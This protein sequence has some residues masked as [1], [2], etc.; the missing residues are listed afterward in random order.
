MEVVSSYTVNYQDPGSSY[1]ILLFFR[2]CMSVQTEMLI[3]RDSQRHRG[4][5]TTIKHSH[6]ALQVKILHKQW[7]PKLSL[8][9]KHLVACFRKC[10]FRF[11]GPK[12]TYGSTIQKSNVTCT[13]KRHPWQ[14]QKSKHGKGARANALWCLQL[15]LHSTYLRE[16]LAWSK[17]C[18]YKP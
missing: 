8:F 10:G 1:L 15:C 2:V 6:F 3:S 17:V 14:F 5:N 4:L 18:L 16:N 12:S 11:C 9:K 7:P 13:V